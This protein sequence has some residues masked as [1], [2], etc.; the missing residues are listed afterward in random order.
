[1]QNNSMQSVGD[2]K[3]QEPGRPKGVSQSQPGT[4]A[5]GAHVGTFLIWN[6]GEEWLLG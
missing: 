4:C 2:G 6:M 3:I 5:K 1:M